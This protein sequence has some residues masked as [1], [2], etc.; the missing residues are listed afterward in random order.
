VTRQPKNLTGIEG[1]ILV[2]LN[3]SEEGFYRAEVHE[4]IRADQ[5]RKEKKEDRL[6]GKTVKI[7]TLDAHDVASVC[8]MK[9]CT[10]EIS[11][12]FA[13]QSQGNIQ[14]PLRTKLTAPAG[15]ILV[16]PSMVEG[17]RAEGS[18]KAVSIFPHNRRKT[19]SINATVLALRRREWRGEGHNRRQKPDGPSGRGSV[20][21]VVQIPGQGRFQDPRHDRGRRSNLSSR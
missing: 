21:P 18:V 13:L 14:S 9:G 5:E 1:E 3:P 10:E 20:G 17:K 7:L 12:S 16:M 15:D 19:P 6:G 11:R 2:R 4:F 8:T